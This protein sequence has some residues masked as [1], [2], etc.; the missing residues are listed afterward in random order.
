MRLG[1][2]K[3]VSGAV[4]GDPPANYVDELVSMGLVYVEPAELPATVRADL[5]AL[6]VEG[7]GRAPTEEELKVVLAFCR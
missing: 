4:I 1:W 3:T 5:E 7:I 6:Y 2:W